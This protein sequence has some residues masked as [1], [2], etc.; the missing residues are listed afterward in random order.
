M[1][2]DPRIAILCLSTSSAT[3]A[4]A[5]RLLQ[6]CIDTEIVQ[7]SSSSLADSRGVPYRKGR[8]KRVLRTPWHP[9]DQRLIPSPSVQLMAKGPI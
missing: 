5:A 2:K 6:G 8:F 3:H 4:D 9:T 1:Q 7:V